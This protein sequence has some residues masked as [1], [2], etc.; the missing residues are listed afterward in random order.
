MRWFFSTYPKF[1]WV[2]FYTPLREW[3]PATYKFA[4]R[5]IVS[6]NIVRFYFISPCPV[7]LDVGGV[8]QMLFNPKDECILPT[9]AEFT[10]DAPP[11]V[12][13]AAAQADRTVLVVQIKAPPDIT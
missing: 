4:G 2:Y 1:T 6:A 5:E 13:Y 7:I 9:D 10:T 8:S 11:Y 3:T 12:Q